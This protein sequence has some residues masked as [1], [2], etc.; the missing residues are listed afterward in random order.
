MEERLKIEKDGGKLGWI[1]Q[2]DRE[3]LKENIFQAAEHMD[4]N[5]AMKSYLMALETMIPRETK[6]WP[7]L[8]NLIAEAFKGD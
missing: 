4:S 1:A 5:K 2:K 7:D 8:P 6:E 3:Y